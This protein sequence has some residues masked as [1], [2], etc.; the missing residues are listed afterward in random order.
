MVN[1]YNDY[2]SPSLPLWYAAQ[3]R[4]RRNGPLDE[5]ASLFKV[6]DGTRLEAMAMR[7]RTAGVVVDAAQRIGWVRQDQVITFEP[8]K[9]GKGGA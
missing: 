1:F 9:V 3:G 7:Q 2:G 5:S 6:R 8:G 4:R